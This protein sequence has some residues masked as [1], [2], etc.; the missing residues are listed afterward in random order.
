[1]HLWLKPAIRGLRLRPLLLVT[2]C[3]P[4][5][6]CSGCRGK[7]AAVLRGLVLLIYKKS[8]ERHSKRRLSVLFLGK[9][10][11]LRRTHGAVGSY[12]SG[13]TGRARRELDSSRT[14]PAPCT[15]LSVN[16]SHCHAGRPREKGCALVKASISCTKSTRRFSPSLGC[17]T[18]FSGGRAGRI[19]SRCLVTSH[20]TA[21]VSHPPWQAWAR[22]G[23][24]TSAR[25]RERSG[26]A[27]GGQGRAALLRSEVRS[28][29]GGLDPPVPACVP[30]SQPW[31]LSVERR[32]RAPSRITPHAS[33]CHPELC[34]VSG[35]SHC[36]E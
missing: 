21:S 4:T 36:P 33:F 18:D 29:E 31:M 20:N 8:R 16:V 17:Q 11:E 23:K 25:Q 30:V 9:V 7:R 35:S 5:P 6:W 15:H 22:Q 27:E 13:G 28:P 14:G 34:D 10:S 26:P 12:P 1:M 3:G 32:A 19:P 2:G 24:T